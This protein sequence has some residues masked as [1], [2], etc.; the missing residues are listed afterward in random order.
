MVFS[1]FSCDIEIISSTF[2]AFKQA[3]IIYGIA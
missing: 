2:T 3:E 1:G